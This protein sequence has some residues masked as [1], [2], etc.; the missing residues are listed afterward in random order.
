[1]SDAIFIRVLEKTK[2]HKTETTVSE[3]LKVEDASVVVLKGLSV[4]DHPVQEP[5]VQGERRDGRQEPAVACKQRST[6][7]LEMFLHCWREDEK[8]EAHP[9]LPDIC[10]FWWLRPQ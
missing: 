3:Y 4:R 1:M 7:E 5:V 9:G 10:L 8:Y 2:K 6:Y